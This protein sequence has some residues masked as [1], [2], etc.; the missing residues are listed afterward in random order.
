MVHDQTFYVITSPT[1]VG[2]DPVAAVGYELMR[3]FVV[4]ADYEHQQL[5]FYNAPSFASSGNGTKVPL[6]LGG[7]VPEVKG[8]VD[9]AS[10]VFFLDTG[11]AFGFALEAG[12][13]RQNDLIKLLG[14]RYHGYAGRDYAGPLAESYYARVK[15]LRIGDAEVNNAIAYLATGE[16]HPE[17]K[18][19]NIGRS[20]LRQFNVIFDCM[21]GPLYLEKN[22][23]WD[24]VDVFNRAGIVIDPMEQG[25]RVMTVLPE[26]P[27]DVAG[28][29]VG[30]IITG[31]DGQPPGDDAEEPAFLQPVGT[32]VRLTVKRGD[33]VRK[34]DVT[35]KDMI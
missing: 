2:D 19:G 12:F 22:A 23:N 3:R 25:Q 8:N 20:V 35:L 31:I 5:T 6:Q 32:V 9:G 34:I 17:E 15:T 30:D 11:N 21:R 18:A 33:A 29:A 1:T 13:V 10:G 4:K 14:A 27:G 26:S 16:P 24:K 28:L 7:R